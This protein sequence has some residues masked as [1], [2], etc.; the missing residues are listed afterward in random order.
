MKTL[1]IILLLLPPALFA[2]PEIERDVVNAGGGST[3]SDGIMLSYSIGEAIIESVENQDIILTQ[4]FLQS[5]DM[6]TDVEFQEENLSVRLYPNPATSK[7]IIEIN[8]EENPDYLEIKL[9]GLAG[10][11]YYSVRKFY[12]GQKQITEKIDISDLSQGS[13][14]IS[15]SNKAFIKKIKLVKLD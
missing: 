14:Y 15:L 3:E 8:F 13:Y 2:Q 7:V 10:R 12:P 4:G 9:T 1:I 11:E 6:L 5:D